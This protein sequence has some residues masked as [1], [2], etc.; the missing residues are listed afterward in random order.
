MALRLRVIDRQ[1]LIGQLIVAGLHLLSL[2]DSPTLQPL[3]EAAVHSERSGFAGRVPLYRR[4][5]MIIA[6]RQFKKGRQ[7]GA[8]ERNDE[9]KRGDEACQDHARICHPSCRS[10]HG[11]G[12]LPQHQRRARS[13]RAHGSRSEVF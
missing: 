7:I 12:T 6:V 13:A 10:I 11:S 1:C 8:I 9:A 5:G 2:V 4:G 3:S